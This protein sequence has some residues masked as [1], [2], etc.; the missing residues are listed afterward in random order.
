[1]KAFLPLLVLG[2]PAFAALPSVGPDYTR[3]SLPVPASYAGQ[4]AAA[5]NT[6]GSLPL[7]WWKQYHDPVL[8]G[9]MEHALSANQNLAAAAARV[10]QA[11]ALTGV[12]RS[13][14]LPSLAANGSISRDRLS[15][16]VA[17][18]APVE[19]SSTHQA[20]LGAS[21]ELDLFGRIR[22]LHEASKAD[23]AAAASLLEDLRLSLEADLAANYLNLR[24]LDHERR[25]VQ[26]SLELRRDTRRLIEARLWAGAATDFDLARADADLASAEAEAL[27]LQERRASLQTAIAVL[28]G[29]SATDFRIEEVLEDSLQ[30]LEVPAGLPGQLLQRRPDLQAAEAQLIS[31][32]AA[33]GA[34]KAAFFPSFTLTGAAG[35]ASSDLNHLGE[36][37]STLWS[38]APSVRLPLFEGGR[39]RARL[40]RSRAAYEEQLALFRQHVLSAVREVQDALNSSALLHQ[41]AEA[42][43]RAVGAARRAGQIA[44]Q[45]Y[46]SGLIGY[47]E[48]LEAQRSVLA[49]ERIQSQLNARQL[50]ANIGL[51]RSLGGG[52]QG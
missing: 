27:G 10:Q 32:N 37:G 51:I 19:E 20:S 38:L 47:Y 6:A 48:L 31:A 52:W 8:D 16:E 36:S 2:L 18:A 12:T 11:R 28:V 45:R 23:A 15:R 42:Q 30:A 17:N 14:F 34:S 33:V 13:A 9:L 49:A 22:R 39:N 41:E 29:S 25:L 40:E 4:A 44:A 7:S 46:K 43:D 50:L 5:V 3:P 26:T 24:A 35:F 21:W 1:M